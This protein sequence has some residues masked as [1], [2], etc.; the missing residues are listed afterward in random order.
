MLNYVNEPSPA[1]AAEAPEA[2][3]EKVAEAEFEEMA[4]TLLTLAK[5]TRALFGLTLAEAGFHN[6]QDHLLMSLVPGEPM[7]VSTLAHV[8]DVRPSTVSKMLDRLSERGLVERREVPRDARLTS[9]CLTK[10]GMRAKKQIRS[11]WA[12]TCRHVAS[13]LPGD[14]LTISQQLGA[15]SEA[16]SARLM[17]LR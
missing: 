4:T 5:R 8:L 2:L 10:A 15:V 9:V 7:T 16:V 6:G 11:V 1:Q 12:D 3:T 14:P 17:R 13:R